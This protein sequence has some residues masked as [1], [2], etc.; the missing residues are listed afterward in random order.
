MTIH[1]VVI[2]GNPVLHRRAAEV[3]DF[4]DELRTLIADM[5]ETN[6]AANGAGLAAP[7][8]GIGLRVFVYAMDNEDGVAPQG[9]LVNPSLVTGKVSGNSPDPDD[10][11]EGCLSVPGYHFP[12]KRAEWVRISGYDGF[13]EKIE[14]EATGWFARCMQHE[15]DHLD[16]KLY[17]DK[18]VDRYKRK[19]RRVAKEHGWGVPGLSWMPGVDPDPFGH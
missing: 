15:Y 16:G 2:Q 8:I 11:A 7:Q 10:E 13:G 12:L 14:F 4:N 17:V 3:T 18:L 1:P 9:V 5:H 19:A 6:T